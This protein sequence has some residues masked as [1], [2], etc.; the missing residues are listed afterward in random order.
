MFFVDE[1]GLLGLPL[2]PGF[3]ADVFVDVFAFLAGHGGE[4]QPFEFFLVFATE[5]G[6]A[7]VC[8]CLEVVL[9]N[10]LG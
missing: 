9:L 4:V 5:Y 3:L 6:A 8:S 10:L 2:F 7:H 1:H